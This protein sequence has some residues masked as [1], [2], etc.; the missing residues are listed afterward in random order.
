MAVEIKHIIKRDGSVK[1]FDVHKIV[2]AIECAGKATNQFGR[3]RAQEITDTLVMPRLREL[4]VAT[5]HIEQVQ[6]AVEHALYEAGHFETLRAYIVYREQRARNRDAKKSWVDVESSINEYLNQSDWRVNA[7][8]NQ[9][10][11]LG[12]L[13]L[14]V[15]GKVI[16]NYWLNFVYTPEIG[17]C[18]RQADFLRYF[19]QRLYIWQFL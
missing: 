6:D 10:Y 4:S 9:G 17:Q 7:N 12:G 5:P 16:A 2:Y 3:E 11:S 14:N 1:D 19:R 15:S 18:H 13:I 8:A